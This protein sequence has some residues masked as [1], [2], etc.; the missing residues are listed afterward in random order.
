MEEI[1]ALISKAIATAFED[2]REVEGVKLRLL[3]L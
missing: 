2:Y 1:Q 3:H